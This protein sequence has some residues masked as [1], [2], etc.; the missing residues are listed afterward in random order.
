MGARG[1]PLC[2]MRRHSEAQNGDHLKQVTHQ[3]NTSWSSLAFDRVS[4]AGASYISHGWTQFLGLAFKA[5]LRWA[6]R[7]WT[8]CWYCTATR[9]EPTSWTWRPFPRNLSVHLTNILTFFWKLRAIG[10]SCFTTLSLLCCIQLTISFGHDWWSIPRACPRLYSRGQDRRGE[11]RERDGVLGEGAAT[12]PYQLRGLRES[13]SGVWGGALK[14]FS[15]IFSTQ[16]DLSWHYNIVNCGLSCSHWG[17]Q[18]PT[19]LPL[20]YAPIRYFVDLCNL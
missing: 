10:P 9:T 19:A 6:S 8:D 14:R 7:D 16:D 11:G 1:P 15:T 20:A 4:A 5:E 13:H 3:G 12:P 18:N 2:E 17:G